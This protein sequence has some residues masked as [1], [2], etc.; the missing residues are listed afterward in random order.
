ML[1]SRMGVGMV[2]QSCGIGL[3]VVMNDVSFAVEDDLKSAAVRGK[4]QLL[5]NL[6]YFYILFSRGN[7]HQVC[8]I[9]S[10]DSLTCN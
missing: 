5:R 1:C 6:G 3:F 7:A 2:F 4:K 10:V 9:S 8:F